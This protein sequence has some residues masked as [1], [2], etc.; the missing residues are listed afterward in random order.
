M[1]TTKLISSIRFLSLATARSTP[2]LLAQAI[3]AYQGNG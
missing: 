3:T 2:P 1:S